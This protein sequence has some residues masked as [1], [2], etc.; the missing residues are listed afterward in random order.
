LEFEVYVRLEF[1]NLEFHQNLSCHWKRRRP[2][3]NYNKATIKLQ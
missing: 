2:Q 3:K 1:W